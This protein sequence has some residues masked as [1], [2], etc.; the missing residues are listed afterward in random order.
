VHEA[1]NLDAYKI[2][3]FIVFTP[4]RLPVMIDAAPSHARQH[5]EWRI[6]SIKAVT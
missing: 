2:D 5:D 6:S 4:R 3:S 1:C